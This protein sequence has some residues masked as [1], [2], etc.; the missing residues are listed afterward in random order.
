MSY[1][2]EFALGAELGAKYAI[3]SVWS[4]DRLLPGAVREDVRSGGQ[5]GM[6]LNLEFVPFSNI[7]A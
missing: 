2:K 6:K 5:N 3:A 7:P 4:A 1:E